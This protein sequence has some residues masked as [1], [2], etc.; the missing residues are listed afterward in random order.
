MEALP[1]SL[2]AVHSFG[3]G[4]TPGSTPGTWEASLISFQMTVLEQGCTLS[5]MS[6]GE[7]NGPWASSP[8]LCTA[9]W[10]LLPALIAG[11]IKTTL[12]EP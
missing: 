11:R 9:V 12:S 1:V 6:L 4:P 7:E 10:P 3:V 5:A 2:L 8:V